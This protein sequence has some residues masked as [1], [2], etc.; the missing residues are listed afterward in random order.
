MALFKK[1][2]KNHLKTR[3][4]FQDRN[5]LEWNNRLNIRVKYVNP[6][7]V[8]IE[9]IPLKRDVLLVIN[10][11]TIKKQQ[12]LIWIVFN[13]WNKSLLLSSTTVLMDIY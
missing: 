2:L 10:R 11:Q 5:N 3:F 1:Q 13:S 6:T 12:C 4:L 8:D 7:K 9:N